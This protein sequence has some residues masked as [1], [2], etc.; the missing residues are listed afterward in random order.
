MVIVA[1]T[2]RKAC[3]YFFCNYIFEASRGAGAQ[4]VPVNRVV[5]GLMMKY[6]FTIIFSFLRSGV[7][8]KVR[9]GVPALNTQCLQK[10]A[11]SGE[12][13]LLILGSLCLPCC[14]RDTA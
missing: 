1:L 9:S 14:V 2:R 10:L 3:Y 5:V 11:E 7:E 4:S 8:A 6:L 13:S 12:R